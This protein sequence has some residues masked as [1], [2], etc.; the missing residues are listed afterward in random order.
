MKKILLLIISLISLTG[1]SQKKEKIKGNREVL[2]KEFS[3]ADFEAIEIGEK[4]AVAIEKTSDTTRIVI[5]TDDNL[6][7]VIHFNVENKTLHFSTSKEIVKKKRLK[8]TVF[9]PEKL[10]SISVIEK[11]KVFNDDK[12]SLDNLQIKANN[13]G[14]INLDLQI[15]NNFVIKASD[16]SKIE[17]TGN[18]QTASVNLADNAKL[19]TEWQVQNV[20]ILLNDYAYFKAKGSAHQ[21]KLRAQN[22]T[23]CKASKWIVK[24]AI[25]SSFDKAETSINVSGNLSLEETGNTAVYIYGSP[26]I[27]LKK[28]NDNASLYKK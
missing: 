5:E 7:D 17:L 18:A 26:K 3:V 20:D 8:I 22:K 28:F 21:L 11:G 24:D 19:E 25:I 12:L 10:N 16:K 4:F 13:R 1:F 9:V 6:F 15:K 23:T 27:N 2:I 14:E